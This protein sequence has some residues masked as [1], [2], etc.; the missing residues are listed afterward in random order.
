MP[1]VKD[2]EFQLCLQLIVEEHKTHRQDFLLRPP[3]ADLAQEAYSRG[4]LQGEE[5]I[6]N[7]LVELARVDLFNRKEAEDANT[8]TERDAGGSGGY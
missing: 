4:Q 8:E 6:I 1:L 2:K 7:R 3:M 5:M